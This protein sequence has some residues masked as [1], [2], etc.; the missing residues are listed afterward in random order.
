MLRCGASG[1][2][3]HHQANW[4]TRSRPGFRAALQE[5]IAGDTWIVDGNYLGSIGDLVWARADTV[6]WLDLPRHVV[7]RQVIWRTLRRILTG[8][9]LWNGNRERVRNFFSLDKEQS[10]IAWAWATHRENRRRFLVAMADPAHRH[11]RFVQL[12]SRGEVDT[13][14]AACQRHANGTL[15]Q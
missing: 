2:W 6:V 7:M 8:E 4:T 15:G 10:V 1:W 14:L 11:L 3:G 5:R 13:F 12:R 9:E